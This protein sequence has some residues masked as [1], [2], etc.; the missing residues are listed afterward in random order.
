MGNQASTPRPGTKLKVIGAGL[1][2]TGTASFSEALRVLLNGPVYHGGTQTTLGK[3]IEIQSWIK[4]LEHWPPENE[5][6][7][8]LGRTHF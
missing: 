1:S 3:P 8:K 6:D 7:R 5:A 4:T 2:R